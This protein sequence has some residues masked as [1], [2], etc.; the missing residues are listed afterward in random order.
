MDVFVSGL[1][2]IP[3]LIGVLH[4][5]FTADL[6][7]IEEGNELLKRLKEDLTYVYL[8]QSRLINFL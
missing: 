3:A 7:I 5:N 2:Q 1:R 4:T 8:L 6:T